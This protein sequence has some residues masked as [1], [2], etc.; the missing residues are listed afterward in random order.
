MFSRL[1]MT[2]IVRQASVE[3]RV[4]HL[5]AKVLTKLGKEADRGFVVKTASLGLFAGMVAFR[6]GKLRY[7][8]GRS[9]LFYGAA[10]L[11]L[12]CH[13]NINNFK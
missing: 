2:A 4:K 11:A 8:L 6:S 3:R 5:H 10:S 13:S 12:G 9:I 7:C 1:M